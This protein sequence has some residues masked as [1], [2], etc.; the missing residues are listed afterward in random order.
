VDDLLVASFVVVA[1]TAQAR[2]S[3]RGH[4]NVYLAILVSHTILLGLGRGRLFAA[5]PEGRAIAP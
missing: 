2:T 5:I 1:I 3:Q 4:V